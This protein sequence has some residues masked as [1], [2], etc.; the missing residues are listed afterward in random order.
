MQQYYLV[1][2]F[3]LAVKKVKS[4]GTLIKFEDDGPGIPKNKRDDV[5]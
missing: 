5:L 1:L 4:K 2:I 3:N